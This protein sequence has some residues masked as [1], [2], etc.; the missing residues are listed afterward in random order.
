MKLILQQVG[1][2]LTDLA[3][4]SEASQASSSGP[5]RGSLFAAINTLERVGETAPDSFSREKLEMEALLLRAYFQAE[6]APVFMSTR[7]GAESPLRR[8]W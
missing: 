8:R 6:A 1:D 7:Q 5:H 4:L 3:R 2:F